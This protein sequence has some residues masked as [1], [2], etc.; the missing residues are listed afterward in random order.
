MDFLSIISVN[1]DELI[2]AFKCSSV[3]LI[4]LSCSLSHELFFGLWRN[5]KRETCGY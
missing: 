2:V 4:S 1:S 5:F 3:S